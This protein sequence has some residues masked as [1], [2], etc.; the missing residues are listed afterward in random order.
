MIYGRERNSLDNS[1][2]KVI[3]Q[4][5]KYLENKKNKIGHLQSII[6][7]ADPENIL[8]RG[9]ALV[10]KDGKVLTDG[11]GIKTGDKISVKMKNTQLETEVTSIKK[12][13]GN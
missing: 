5:V 12:K 3:T 2:S 4:S 8:N 6:K 10:M 11:M 7:M 1:F 13:D 9:F